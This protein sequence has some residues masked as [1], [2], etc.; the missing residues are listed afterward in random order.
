MNNYARVLDMIPDLNASGVTGT[1]EVTRIDRAIAEASRAFRT[2]AGGRQMHS[3]TETRY[4]DGDGFTYLYVNDLISITTLKFDEDGDGTYAETLATTDYWLWPD[5]RQSGYA[6]RRIDLNPEGD[7]SSFPVGRRRIQIVGKWGHSEILEAVVGTAAVTGTLA[8]A[9][10][11]T[12]ACS[13]TVASLLA[14]GDTLILE[15]EQIGPVLSVAT[16]TVTVQARGINGTTAAAHAAVQVYLR[17]FPDDVERAVRADAGRYLWSASSG[18][19]G[20]TFRD[21]WPA[22]ADCVASYTDPAAVI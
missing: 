4:F 8:D 10:D 15:S 1:T 19:E 3:T 11:L 20:S 9:I 21:K 7:Y 17:R 14:R 6:A 13:E 22:I 5:N 2:G 16:T 18:F 12:L